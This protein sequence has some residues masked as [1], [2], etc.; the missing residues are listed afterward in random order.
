MSKSNKSG[1]PAKTG[2]SGKPAKQQEKKI[3]MVPFLYMGIIIIFVTAL[4]QSL[5]KGCPEVLR[6]ILYITG[7]LALIVYMMQVAFEKRTGK[8]EP[9][10][11]TKGQ[12]LK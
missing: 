12:R 10:G 6:N 8:S 9:D 11:E 5:W 4:L 3:T 7:V 1:K 2:K